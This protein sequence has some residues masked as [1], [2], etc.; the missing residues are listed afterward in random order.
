MVSRRYVFEFIFLC[1][2]HSLLFS[3]RLRGGNISRRLVE[4]S[5]LAF[6][7]AR[8]SVRTRE[9]LTTFGGR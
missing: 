2:L 7:R 9:S 3:V 5:T 8:A 1:H 6:A 4:R